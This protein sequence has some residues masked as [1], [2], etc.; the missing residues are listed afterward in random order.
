M[1]P[2]PST[3]DVD[4]R[5]TTLRD[6]LDRMRANL[7]E[8]DDDVT[9]RTLDAATALRGRT[10]EAWA[11]VGGSMTGLWRSL[12]ALDA[13]VA[14]LVGLRGSRSTINRATLSRLHE[15]LDGPSVVLPVTTGSDLPRS[16]TAGPDPVSR[17]TVDEVVATMSEQYARLAAVVDTVYRTWSTVSPELGALSDELAR[18]LGG[19]G[20]EAGERC[21]RSDLARALIDDYR[22]LAT[23]DPLGLPDNA[24]GSAHSAV[25][26]ARAEL[27]Q[28]A[29][30]RAG[31]EDE[32]AA[33]ADGL[34]AT[35]VWLDAGHASA[36]RPARIADRAGDRAGPSQIRLEL[37]EL[38]RDLLAVRMMARVRPSDAGRR[39][40]VL[41][42]RVEV[43]ATRA[44][45]LAG[46]ESRG[47]VERDELRGRLD[48]LH[49]KAH[50][51]GRAE[52]PE[53]EQVRQQARDELYCAP[54]DLERSSALVDAYQRAVRAIGGAG[55]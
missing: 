48:A 33:I 53:L 18:L 6:T 25:D 19:T 12:L 10:A 4:A 52:D 20:S 14:E 35:R 32:V 31:L 5:I 46:F 38:D 39:A 41:R 34:A 30:V 40:Q 3:H 37:D 13:V 24:L 51:L 16:L 42:A 17:H 15:L 7:V 44:Q 1:S 43:L 8:L 54:C 50:A 29:E 27:T 28:A 26:A 36:G 47:L 55:R 2:A 23:H 49:A 22:E 9:R 21:D 11:E 45:E